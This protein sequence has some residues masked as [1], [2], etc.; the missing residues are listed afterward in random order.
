MAELVH[1]E[2]AVKVLQGALDWAGKAVHVIVD[3]IEQARTPQK[4]LNSAA[5]ALV[6][7][8]LLSEANVLALCGPVLGKGCTRDGILYIFLYFKT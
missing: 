3:M 2:V 6:V 1:V 4:V 7:A 8:I 5:L